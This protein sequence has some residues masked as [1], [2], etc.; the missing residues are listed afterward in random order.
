MIYT[1]TIETPLGVMRAAAADGSL[2]GLWF[3]GQ[4]YYPE[5]TGFW[6]PDQEYPVFEKLRQWLDAYFAGER[7]APALPLAPAGTEFRQAVWNRIREIPYGG[8]SSYGEIARKI[9]AEKKIASMSG[10][11]VGGAVGHN[12][13]SLLIPCHRVVGSDGRLTGYAGGME[14]KKILLELERGCR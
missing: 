10:Q 6:Q 4:K 9:A 7:P 8:T 2:T 5:A 14:K 11:A 13:I 1:C 3:E 12:P